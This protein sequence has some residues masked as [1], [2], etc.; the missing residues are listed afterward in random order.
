MATSDS[1]QERR[2][3]NDPRVSLRVPFIA[4]SPAIPD[5]RGT[6]TCTDLSQRGA[7]IRLGKSLSSGSAIQVTLQVCAVPLL[8]LEG[9]VAWVQKGSDA[10]TWVMGIEFD[11]ELPGEL[12]AEIAEAEPSAST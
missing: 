6:G 3:S 11:G 1:A 4:E 10:S 9:R 12:I 7:G 8:K 5:Q 2:R